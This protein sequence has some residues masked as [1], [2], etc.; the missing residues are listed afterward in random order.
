MCTLRTPPAA[1]LPRE[2]LP[3][4]AHPRSC[5]RWSGPRRPPIHW[6]GLRFFDTLCPLHKHLQTLCSRS[7]AG[8]AQHGGHIPGRP[9]RRRG[10]PCTCLP[11][12]ALGQHPHSQCL[13]AHSIASL[14]TA[15]TVCL[16]PRVHW[17]PCRLPTR[18]ARHPRRLH[19]P[20]LSWRGRRLND[21][22]AVRKNMGFEEE[23]WTMP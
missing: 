2:P 18:R 13:L 20:A 16:T 5:R 19:A 1:A 11:H 3:T 14:P 10:K 6:R 4:P 7:F 15:S 22:E 17:G 23:Q 21:F 12:P 9:H 8:Q